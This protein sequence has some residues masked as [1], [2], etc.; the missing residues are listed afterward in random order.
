MR[1]SRL[2]ADSVALS[3]G[4]AS[5]AA[6]ARRS[7]GSGWPCRRASLAIGIGPFGGSFG[8]GAELRAGRLH[9][10]E[11]RRLP[12]RRHARQQCTY[13]NQRGGYLPEQH[14]CQRPRG[15]QPGP[16]LRRVRR[17]VSVDLVDIKGNSKG[18]TN[19]TQGGGAAKG[20]DANDSSGGVGIG[21]D[22]SASWTSPNASGGSTARRAA[23]ATYADAL[24]EIPGEVDGRHR[25]DPAGPG[26]R[27]RRRPA[28]PGVHHPTGVF[29]QYN[30]GYRLHAA[31][32][33]LTTGGFEAQESYAGSA[34]LG[35]TTPLGGVLRRLRPQLELRPVAL[36]VGRRQRR[37]HPRPDPQDRQQR[38]PKVRFG[39]G[40]GMLPPVEYGDMARRPTRR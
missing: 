29:A 8:V 15:H 34:S 5:R 12:R 14:R 38:A 17:A 20:G 27:Q 21:G 18:K 37:R 19:A 24:G 40:S 23:N 26:R 10:H 13:T 9:G 28:R 6:A 35:F 39:T 1:T 7:P 2:G 30:L 22:F 31:A 3:S 16:D 11:R 32:V 4:P 25:A 36:H 33:K